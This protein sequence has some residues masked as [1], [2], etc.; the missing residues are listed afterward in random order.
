MDGKRFLERISSAG[1]LS[2]GFP[3]LRLQLKPLNV[4]IG[5]N[6]SGKS[7]LVAI[8]G[9]LA[10][11]PHD[12]A[13]AFR[14]GGGIVEWIWKGGTGG[15]GEDFSFVGL[16]FSF[17]DEILRYRIAVDDAAAIQSRLEISS[18]MLAKGYGDESNRLVDRRNLEIPRGQSILAGLKD[19]EGYPELTYLGRQLSKIRLY[20][21]WDLGRN[22]SIRRPQLADLPEDFL[23]DDGSN[24]ALVLNDLENRPGIK[25]LLLGQLNRLYRRVENFTTKVQGGTVQ[26]FF[27]EEGLRQPVPASRLSDGTLH[28]LCL[29]SILCHPDPPPLICIEEPEVGLHPDIIP[30]VAK[31]L[32]DAS[33]RTQL[34]VTTHSEML[35]SA[36]SEVPESVIVCER[37]DNG[38]ELQ[39]LE[40]EKLKEWLENY[41]LGELWSM[42][43]IGGNP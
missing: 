35:V 24:L 33:Q 16:D 11:A 13:R 27:H 41:R 39:R 23:L 36:L 21:N 7:N 28:Y 1:F 9:L 12:L 17:K 2:Y 26:I 31:L 4:L 34:V 43:E 30:E 15:K 25:R 40:H 18:E 37:G 8:L 6:G 19:P 32:I 29:L 38:T 5:P 3:G 14:E 10:A 22:S 20:R 42:G